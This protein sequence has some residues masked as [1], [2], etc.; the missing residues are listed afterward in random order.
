MQEKNFSWVPKN[1][2]KQ[3]ITSE[4]KYFKFDK[5]NSPR[6]LRSLFKFAVCWLTVTEGIGRNYEFV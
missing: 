3:K 1:Q 6:I 5:Y 4:M 2:N